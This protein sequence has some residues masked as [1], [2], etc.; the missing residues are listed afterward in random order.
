[1]IRSIVG[2][3]VVALILCVAVL[4]YVGQSK[5]PDE[6]IRNSV[7]RSA[8]LLQRGF[9]LPVASRFRDRLV[10]QSNASVCG[11]ASL[12]NVFR[13]FGDTPDTEAAILVGAKRCWFNVC[14]FGLTLDEI[15]DLAKA[16]STRRV[17]VLRDLTPEH[18]HAILRDTNNPKR[19]Y[20][21]NFSRQQ[22]FGA[23]VGHVSPIGGYLEAEDLVLVLDVNEKFGPWLVERS[24]L[25]RAVDTLDGQRKRGLLRIE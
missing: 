25:F 11:A 12:A 1:M 22:I 24:R 14:P 2:S 7:E 4:V 6:A 23:G 13:S 20:I 17:D 3:L 9:G 5:V 19:R 16:S 21:A 10:S 15:A 18:F 8:E